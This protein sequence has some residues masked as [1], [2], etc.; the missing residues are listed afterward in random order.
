MH[1]CC[2]RHT[3]HLSVRGESIFLCLAEKSA[4]KKF[5][6]LPFSKPRLCHCFCSSKSAKHKRSQLAQVDLF[7]TQRPRTSPRTYRQTP[8]RT[9][10]WLRICFDLLATMEKQFAAKVDGCKSIWSYV[11]MW[12]QDKHTL[13]IVVWQVLESP[14][15]TPRH[16]G[17]AVHRAFK[18]ISHTTTYYFIQPP[19]ER[20]PRVI[21]TIKSTLHFETILFNLGTCVCFQDEFAS[22][23]QLLLD[24]YC[25]KSDGKSNF[26]TRQSWW[27]RMTD[28]SFRL[29]LP[30]NVRSL[31][32]FIT[33]YMCADS[34]IE[35]VKEELSKVKTTLINGIGGLPHSD[36]QPPFWPSS[37]TP[38]AILILITKLYSSPGTGTLMIIASQS[39]EYAHSPPH[40]HP[41]N[42]IY[43]IHV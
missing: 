29:H 25:K 11:S 21:F 4:S 22:T 26:S 15:S 3:F 16:A 31:Q 34:K 14:K 8:A 40:A 43:T 20:Q 1:T 36:P 2:G 13:C 6:P 9:C 5:A 27:F 41:R 28:L 23:L 10:L 33:L 24:Q 42:F 19:P 39:H 32:T 35:L 7:L 37:C 18:E 17:L 30:E 38:I 12:R